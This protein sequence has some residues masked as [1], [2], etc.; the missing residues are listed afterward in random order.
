MGHRIISFWLQ[1]DNMNATSWLEHEDIN[2]VM[3]AAALA[4]A[5]FILLPGL[6]ASAA[7]LHA[8]RQG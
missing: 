5:G 2:S 4:P 7:G 6:D 3:L 8:G 1:D